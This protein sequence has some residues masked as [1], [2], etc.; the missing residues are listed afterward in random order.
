MHQLIDGLRGVEV[1]ANDF[2]V[3]G[4]GDTEES[5]VQDH[6]QN[7]QSFLQR[8][9]VRGIKLNHSNIALRQKTVPF[10]GHV[11]TGKALCVDPAKVQ[12]QEKA[13]ED[14]KKAIVSTPIL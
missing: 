12:P 3:F 13:L 6:D 5:A 11:A 7:L 8:C 1:I 4:F 10:I 14:L 9:A 2:V